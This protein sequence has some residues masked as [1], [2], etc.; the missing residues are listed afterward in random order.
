MS[1]MIGDFRSWMSEFGAIIVCGVFLLAAAKPAALAQTA[2]TGALAGIVTDVSGAV[3][4]DAD[5]AVV[6][7]ST[8]ERRTTVS[9]SNGIYLVPL[10]PP[11]S[12][13]VSVS[14]TGFKLWVNSGIPV[15]VTETAALNVKLEVGS[16]K[17]TVEVTGAGEQLQTETSA[18]GRVTDSGSWWRA[19]LW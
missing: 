16:V 15:H 9:R 12:Y 17:E 1:R 5:I 19:C 2:G 6:S 18:L 4:A 3:V 11:G 7:E 14:K 10:L 8:G 13:R